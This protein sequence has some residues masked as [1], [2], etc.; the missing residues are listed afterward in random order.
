MEKMKEFPFFFFATFIL[1]QKFQILFV[2]LIFYLKKKFITIH[3]VSPSQVTITGPTEAKSGEIVNFNCATAPS[4]PPAEIRWT[5]DGRQR[6]SNATKVE[7]SNE[8]GSITYSNISI[9]VGANKRSISLLCQGINMQ[10]PDN[11]MTTQ[12]LTILCE[13][14]EINFLKQIKS[15]YHFYYYRSAID[16]DNF[17][18]YGRFRNSCRIQSKA[19]MHVFRWKSTTHTDLVQERKEGKYEESECL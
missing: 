3:V 18:L 17:G 7:T 4:H 11:V 13:C 16:T 15:I 14:D 12:V 2:L 9:E 5:I 1:E 6:R 8:G 19:S 10:L